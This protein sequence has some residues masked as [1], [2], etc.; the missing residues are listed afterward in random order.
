M[1]VDETGD[2]G[3]AAE[4]DHAGAAVAPAAHVARRADGTDAFALHGHGTGGG[5]SPVESEDASVGENPVGR[6]FIHP[7]S[8]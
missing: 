8:R 3:G 6:Y 5:P 7:F 2:D 1:R 4:I